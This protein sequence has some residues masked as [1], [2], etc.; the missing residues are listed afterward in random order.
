MKAINRRTVLSTPSTNICCKLDPAV[1]TFSSIPSLRCFIII[2]Y[3]II[4]LSSPTTFSPLLPF[5]PKWGKDL[6]KTQ[7]KTSCS[8]QSPAA[9]PSPSIVFICRWFSSSCASGSPLFHSASGVQRKDCIVTL[10]P[11]FLNVY[12]CTSTVC[13]AHALHR[14]SL[15]SCL[16]EL[17]NGHFAI[18]F[19][20]CSV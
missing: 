1:A 3:F 15:I 10:L 18:R 2:I 19:P 17:H 9:S 13:S 5:I 14:W 20:P 4:I 8:L 6:Q 16:H 7:T 12:V 11:Y